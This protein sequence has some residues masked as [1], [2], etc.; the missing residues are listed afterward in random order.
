MNKKEKIITLIKWIKVGKKFDYV[1]ECS[2]C[3]ATKKLKILQDY[4]YCPSCK[5]DLRAN[6]MY[7]S[8]F[9]VHKQQIIPTFN[10]SDPVKVIKK[11]ITKKKTSKRKSFI[12]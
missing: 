11:K 6:P 10:Y 8:R 4:F 12:K 7:A 2:F 9:V 1:V 3:G 5:R